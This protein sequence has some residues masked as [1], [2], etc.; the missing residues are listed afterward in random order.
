MKREIPLATC[1]ACGSTWL[2]AGDFYAFQQE[3]RVA[4]EKRKKTTPCLCT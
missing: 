4:P 3:K 2:R 1:G